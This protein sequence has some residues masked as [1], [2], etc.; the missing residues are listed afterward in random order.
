M[1]ILGY[2]KPHSSINIVEK[3]MFGETATSPSVPMMN[4]DSVIVENL[5]D[6]NR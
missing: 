5:F 6:T 1:S 2:L 4:S 3:S